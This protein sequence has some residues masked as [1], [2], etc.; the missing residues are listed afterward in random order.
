MKHVSYFVALAALGSTALLLALGSFVTIAI[1]LISSGVGVRLSPETVKAM[2]YTAVALVWSFALVSYWIRSRGLYPEI[3]KVGRTARLAWGD[4][5]LIG[6]HVLVLCI[7]VVK[8]LAFFMIL[9][10]LGVLL[11]YATAILLIEG[12]RDR[13]KPES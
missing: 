4:R 3:I 6:G 2:S 5:C 7:L 8:D 10:V 13:R 1:E 9:P 12:A 11:L